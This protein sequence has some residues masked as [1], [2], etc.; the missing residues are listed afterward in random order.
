MAAKKH[1]SDGN[2]ALLNFPLASID[3][4]SMALPPCHMFCQF[5]VSTPTDN[6]ADWK[7]SCILYQRS[8]DVGLGVPFNI[9]S[10]AIL[11]RVIAHACGIQAGE[12]IHNMGDAHVYKDHVDAL[13][14]QM[15]R[16]PR[17]FPRLIIKTAPGGGLE[18]LEKLTVDDFELVGYEPHGKL[19]MTMSV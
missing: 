1:V 18:A 11:T 3:L 6:K 13:T 8:C 19:N 16:S 5:Y 9:A 15:G 14:V 2:A 12:F 17:S 10:Y 4:P 7:L